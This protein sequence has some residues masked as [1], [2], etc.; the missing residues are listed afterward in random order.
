MHSTPMTKFI[1]TTKA[2]IRWITCSIPTIKFDESLMDKLIWGL[3][4]ILSS[5]LK[6]GPQLIVHDA[7]CSCARDVHNSRATK[8]I[9]QCKCSS[10]PKHYFLAHYPQS[11]T[12]TLCIGNLLPKQAHGSTNRI[13]HK[14]EY[15]LS[16]N[17]Q[18]ILQMNAYFSQTNAKDS[19]PQ[20]RQIN[21]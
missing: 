13:S 2:Q 20:S 9:W 19:E 17:I 10:T 4:V 6:I 8:G 21:N 3:C 7:S 12:K 11:R 16:M 14:T 15:R 18:L 1:F 5:A